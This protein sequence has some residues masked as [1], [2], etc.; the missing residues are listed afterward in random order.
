MITKIVM[1]VLLSILS[2]VCGVILNMYENADSIDI[3][4]GGIIV[5]FGMIILAVALLGNLFYRLDMV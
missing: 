4:V 5:I 1:Y 3:V 2:I